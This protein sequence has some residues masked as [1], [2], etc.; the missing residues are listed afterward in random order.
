MKTLV[1][2][3][4]GFIGSHLV[5][6]LV[7]ASH[8]VVGI[9]NLSTGD[10]YLFYRDL[11]PNYIPLEC[12]I[13]DFF[14]HPSYGPHLGKEVPWQHDLLGTK[15]LDVIFH[16]AAI[17]SVPRSVEDPWGTF[18]TN[19]CGTQAM[20]ELAVSTGANLIFA[21]SSSVYGGQ[22]PG[23]EDMIPDPK[24]PYAMQKLL[25]EKLCEWYSKNRGL[26][27]VCTRFFN[28]YGLR[29]KANNVDGAVVPRFRKACLSDKPMI[30]HGT[31]EQTRDFSH[32]NDVVKAL[33]LVNQSFGSQPSQFLE[34][35]H[36]VYNVGTGCAISI[37][38]LADIISSIIGSS[39]NKKYISPRLEDVQASLAD[40][41]RITT[42]GYKPEID[43]MRGL[44]L[45]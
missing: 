8:Q 25:G 40:V 19:V 34:G 33:L 36:H 35:S 26:K 9:D 41:T 11:G 4:A 5:D 13:L 31:G 37:N 12:S 1:T 30:I 2:G 42:L 10:K 38:R 17:P 29:Q 28:V 7:Q 21:S 44:Q 22:T 32:V 45:F 16:L 24:S 18:E 27:T 23:Q 39:V 3:A 43:I 14:N 15:S 20:L 6:S